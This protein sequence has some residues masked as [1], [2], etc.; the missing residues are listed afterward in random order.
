MVHR[1]LL[2]LLDGK[3]VCAT[4]EDEPCVVDGNPPHEEGPQTEIGGT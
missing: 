4:I 2:D 1:E 3:R